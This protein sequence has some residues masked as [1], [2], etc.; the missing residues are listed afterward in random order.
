MLDVI[1]AGL[2]GSGGISRAHVRA[3]HSVG[4]RQARVV[5]TC[6]SRAELA[7][8]RAEEAGAEAA[9]TDWRA[10]LDRGDVD[11]VDICLPHFLVCIRD[12]KEALTNGEDARRTLAVALAAYQSERTGRAVN[13]LELT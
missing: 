9:V 11:A 13:P 5:V 12:G 2:I 3:Y 7:A 4:D 1:R 10:V 6:D 8:E